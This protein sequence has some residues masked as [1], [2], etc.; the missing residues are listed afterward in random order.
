MQ[1]LF[2]EQ[3]FSASLKA[4]AK[5]YRTKLDPTVQCNFGQC[6]NMVFNILGLIKG[7]I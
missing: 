1:Q 3:D 4:L 7:R 2:A 5:L 6:S